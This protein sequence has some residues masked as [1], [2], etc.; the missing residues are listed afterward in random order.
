[1]RL[2]KLAATAT[3]LLLGIAVL[4]ALP[5]AAVAASDPVVEESGDTVTYTDPALAREKTTTV[6]GTLRIA[7]VDGINRAGRPNSKT[8]YSVETDDGDSVP[9]EVAKEIP[10]SAANGDIEAEVVDAGSDAAQLAEA[11]VENEPAR[12]AAPAP[13]AH[14]AYVVLVSKTGSFPTESE[15][16]SRLRDNV[17]D[18]WVTESEGAI[19][20]FNVAD[21]ATL[22]DSEPSGHSKTSL[23]AMGASAMQNADGLWKA[24][25]DL[26]PGVDFDP[27]GSSNHLI[28]LVSGDGCYPG[29]KPLFLGIAE[30]GSDVGSGG[31]STLLWDTNFVDATGV[32]ELGHNFSLGHANVEGAE[33]YDLYSVMGFGTRGGQA[34]ALD[35]LYRDRLGL[36]GAGEVARP[37]DGTDETFDLAARGLGTGLRSIAVTDPGSRVTYWIDYRTAAGRDAGSTFV[38][39]WINP[40]LRWAPGVVVYRQATDYTDTA[41]IDVVKREAGTKDDTSWTDEQTFRSPSGRVQVSVLSTD[42]NVASL[43]VIVGGGSFIASSSPSISGTLRVGETVSAQEGSFSPSAS[44]YRYQWYWRGSRVISGATSKT[45]K[46]SA[47]YRGERLRVRV[48]GVR[49]GYTSKNTITGN[50]SSIAAGVFS[51]ASPSVIGEARVGERLRAVVGS[52]SPRPSS[53]RYQWYAWS[54]AIPGAT[55]SSY[56]V[57]SAYRGSR[58]RVRVTGSRFG[59]TS[60]NTISGYTDAVAN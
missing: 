27:N 43:R 50:S 7:Y 26:F 52:Y 16:S 10:T 5:T 15:V 39:G 38:T 34:P 31:S 12:A 53:Y 48:T 8:S 58:L 25:A 60:K 6:E 28:M 30:V 56:T 59:Y 40:G 54:S 17:L 19:S 32:H 36:T 57:S 3:A 33:Y 14:Q 55:S 45:F 18:E 47:G 37:S 49:S 24:G 22:S 2:T 46:I 29:G 51:A 11:T 35:S 13:A 21:T 20:S 1:M 41:D 23:C 4:T 42:E 9:I 44:S